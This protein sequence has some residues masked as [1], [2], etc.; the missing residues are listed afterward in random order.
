MSLSEQRW[1]IMCVVFVSREGGWEV[2]GGGGD[3]VLRGQIWDRRRGRD[4]N[5]TDEWSLVSEPLFYVQFTNLN[6]EGWIALA[7]STVVFSW[8]GNFLCPSV[9]FRCPVHRWVKQC[10]QVGNPFNMSQ[11]KERCWYF[12]EN[13]VLDV[14]LWIDG[15]NSLHWHV[16]CFAH[17]NE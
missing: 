12:G 5:W 7:D 11:C 13:G 15:A 3:G 1:W 16:G 17:K 2:D 14:A 8:A 10:K 9:M 6:M 4:G